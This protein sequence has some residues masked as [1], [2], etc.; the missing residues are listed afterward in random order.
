VKFVHAAHEPLS[1]E[2]TTNG[3]VEPSEWAPVRADRAGRIEKLHVT[4]G[5]R[6]SAGTPL[7][8]LDAQT[9]KDDV[10]RAEARIAQVKAEIA[11]L[12]AGGRAADRAALDAALANARIDATQVRREIGSVKRLL[13]KKAATIKERVDLEDR[14]SRIE[15]DIKGLESRRAALTDTSDRAA[16]EA[17]LRE[18]QATLDAARQR[19][20]RSVILAS[21]S[22]EVYNLPVRA[23]TYLQ[24]GDLV[25]EIGDLDRLRILIY[26]DEPCP[27]RSPGTG[28]RA[29]NGR[30]SSTSCRSRLPLWAAAK[31]E[32]FSR[33][34]RTSRAS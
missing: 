34:W 9:E 28:S 22:G 32:K 20:E 18:A 8:T 30:E 11:Q 14:L 4:R 33:W 2:L 27:S 16:A 31:W 17:R 3:K 10:A 25:A 24:P 29:A 13:E 21:R 15:S 12:D 26:V 1:S 23:G 7:V 5:A 19:L 6:V